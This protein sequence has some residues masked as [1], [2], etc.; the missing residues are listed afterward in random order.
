MPRPYIRGNLAID[1]DG[2]RI[3]KDELETMGIIPVDHAIPIYGE[4]LSY[5]IAG[6]PGCGKSTTAAEIISLFPRMPV[7]LFTDLSEDDRAFQGLPIRK[8]KLELSLL[9]ELTPELLL[10]KGSC[11]VIFD[12]IDKIRD[13]NINKALIDLMDNI[14]ANGRNHG[15]GQINVIAT[16]HSLT[17]YRKTKYTIENSEYWVIFPNKTIRSQLLT[18]LKKMSLEKM[19]IFDQD[20]VFIHHSVPL[21]IATDSFISLI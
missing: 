14:I 8:M 18:L 16:S 1:R 20:R 9:K 3:T 17:D 5:F 19:D 6:P 12:D 2:T 4:R 7:Y 21:F 15:K 13:K 10:S 11:W